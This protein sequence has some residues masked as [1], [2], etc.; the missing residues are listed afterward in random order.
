[1]DWITGPAIGTFETDGSDGSASPEIS[2]ALA[3]LAASTPAAA[4][5]KWRR[6][7][8]IGDPQS[9]PFGMKRG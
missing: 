9:I 5:D 3:V 2:C 4:T 7:F 1:M 8:G 6:N